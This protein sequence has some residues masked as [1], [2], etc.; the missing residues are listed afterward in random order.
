MACTGGEGLEVIF[1][2]IGHIFF[3]RKIVVI[4]L[5]FFKEL[6]RLSFTNQIL[7]KIGNFKALIENG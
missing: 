4:K 6:F 1:L 5:L 2:L 7:K 3:F